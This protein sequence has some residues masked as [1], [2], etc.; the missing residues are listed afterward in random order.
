M[1]T[2]KQT[3]YPFSI[4]LNLTNPHGPVRIYS[5]DRESSV[6]RQFR[7]WQD[8]LRQEQREGEWRLCLYRHTADSI[9]KLFTSVMP[10]HFDDGKEH[11]YSVTFQG[12][13]I[14]ASFSHRD[15]KH[16]SD[17]EYSSSGKKIK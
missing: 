11:I 15:L 12:S 13:K 6:R 4:V 16:F 14:I 7:I 8:E 10:K 2:L 1:R 5:T 9:Q 17:L 3:K